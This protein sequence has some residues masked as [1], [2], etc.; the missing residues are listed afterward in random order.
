LGARA[1]GRADRAE[2]LQWVDLRRFSAVSTVPTDT[3]RTS[4][5]LILSNRVPEGSTAGHTARGSAA[6]AGASA[7]RI[8]QLQGTANTNSYDGM[9]SFVAGP[10]QD[11]SIIPHNA[12]Y[13]WSA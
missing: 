10:V 2:R 8:L 9:P 4:G 12:I 5:P 7:S 1:A 11:S 3:L 13:A 6:R